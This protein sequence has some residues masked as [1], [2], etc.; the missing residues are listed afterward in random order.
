MK[1]VKIVTKRKPV[2]DQEIES[3]MD[4]N[5]VLRRSA[6]PASNPLMNHRAFLWGS[7]G[8]LATVGS[9]IWLATPKAQ[10]AATTKL[11]NSDAITRVDTLNTQPTDIIEAPVNDRGPAHDPVDQPKPRVTAADELSTQVQPRSDLL[12][13]KAAP[14]QGYPDLY[15]Y[16]DR[17]L[18]YPVTA[19]ADSIQGTTSVAFVLNSSGQPSEV[20]IVNSLGPEFDL[21]VKRLIEN[22]P[23]WHPARL[24]GKAVQSKI[25]LP[26]TFRI[27]QP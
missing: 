15:A 26:I 11:K 23:A 22:M 12:Y 13:E 21:E 27:N 2:S 25:L 24:N 17:E 18:R 3:Y 5:E 8:L 14:V 4:F 19:L 7:A 6:T 10:E 9:L 20:T 1:E 16:F